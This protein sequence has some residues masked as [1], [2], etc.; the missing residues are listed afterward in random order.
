MSAQA[1]KV[2]SNSQFLTGSIEPAIPNQE[3]QRLFSRMADGDES[4]MAE[5]YDGTN[6]L[7]FG[8]LVRMLG[9]VAIAEEILV[10]AY[11]EIW[12]RAPSYESEGGTAFGWL[13]GVVRSCA[14]EKVRS[15]S[16]RPKHEELPEPL[17]RAS[18]LV[19]EHDADAAAQRL[20][21]PLLDELSPE[22]N[23]VVELAY[24]SCLRQSEISER[25]GQPIELVARHV[26]AGMLKLRDRLKLV[27][28]GL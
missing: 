15:E 26:R 8:L 1:N 7:A 11:M 9:D 28:G 10:T 24:F 12:R 3:L 20:R 22:E 2:K 4:A 21:G 27:Q 19:E 16:A 23:Q 25:L 13:I 14:V 17:N 5:L 18:P 6:R